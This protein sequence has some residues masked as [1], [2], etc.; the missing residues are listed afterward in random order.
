[1][2][3]GGDAPKILPS[4]RSIFGPN[5]KFI[6]L[7][8]TDLLTFHFDYLIHS[9]KNQTIKFAKKEGHLKTG[10]QSPPSLFN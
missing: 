8:P 6:L 2:E 1:M 10:Y 3:Q 4:K 9:L 7:A 5:Q